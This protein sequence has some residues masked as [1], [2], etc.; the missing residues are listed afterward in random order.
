MNIISLSLHQK[1]ISFSL[2]VKKNYQFQLKTK[3]K[4]GEFTFYRD[5]EKRVMK[6]F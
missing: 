1:I 6:A 4:R 5:L 3:D 2:C